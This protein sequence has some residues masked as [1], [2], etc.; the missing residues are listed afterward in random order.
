MSRTVSTRVIWI[1]AAAF[2]MV[3]GAIIGRQIVARRHA[4]SAKAET[5]PMVSYGDRVTWSGHDILGRP[6]TIPCDTADVLIV[7]VDLNKGREALELVRVLRDGESGS[8]VS[9]VLLVVGGDTASLRRFAQYAGS[10]FPVTGCNRARDLLPFVD[11]LSP[12]RAV[13][14]VEPN[15]RT[16]LDLGGTTLREVQLVLAQW[17]GWRNI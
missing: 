13:R 6:V 12:G 14:L 17:C 11:S 9:V 3:N 10:S 1:T 15:G 7:E 2:L 16:R 8:G 5:T 4:V